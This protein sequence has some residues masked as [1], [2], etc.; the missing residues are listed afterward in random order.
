MSTK[1]LGR[2]IVERGRLTGNIFERRYSHRQA[3]AAIRR[4]LAT[5]DEEGYERAHR[6]MPV[7]EYVERNLTDKLGPIHRWLDHQ[8]G[9]PWNDVYSEICTRFPWDT[10]AGLHIIRSHVLP[11]VFPV[12]GPESVRSNRYRVDE[13]GIFV[14]NPPRAP[15]PFIPYP[16]IEE[17]AVARAWLGRRR[18]GLIG[19]RYYWFE[20]ARSWPC[21][22]QRCRQCL[23]QQGR[24]PTEWEG[25]YWLVDTPGRHDSF[26]QGPLLTNKEQQEFLAL[27]PR[28]RDEILA[29][30]PN[31][32]AA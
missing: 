25:L 18:I 9:R 23:E 8:V 3:R 17:K 29:A 12:L 16:R 24:Y 15:K 5:L 14:K 32:A 11:E 1:F 27:N 21:Q 19:S 13:E 31:Q 20:L 2:T 7:T 4:W 22:C 6:P 26:R 30:A 10:L 28:L